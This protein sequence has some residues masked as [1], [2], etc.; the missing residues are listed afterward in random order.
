MPLTLALDPTLTPDGSYVLDLAA[1]VERAKTMRR[2]TGELAG[3]VQIVI[4]P[5]QDEQPPIYTFADGRVV[6]STEDHV[7]YADGNPVGLTPQ[8]FAIVKLLAS[9]AGMVVTTTRLLN[10]IW[11]GVDDKVTRDRL[12]QAVKSARDR[13]IPELRES[14]A[15]MR[16]VGYTA[17][18]SLEK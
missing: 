15:T 10:R 16:G 11:D 18:K 12:H 5:Q 1:V 4:T 17:L 9:N 7:A 8:G 2:M 3:A 14:I 13:F 6:V